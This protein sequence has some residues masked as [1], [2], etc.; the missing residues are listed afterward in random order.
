MFGNPK[1]L[2]KITAHQKLKCTL[3]K[4]KYASKTQT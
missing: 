1:H 4:M 2:K 3:F